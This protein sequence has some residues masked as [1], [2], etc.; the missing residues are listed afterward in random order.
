MHWGAYDIQA[1]LK[2]VL[3]G[4][5]TGNEPISIVCK[6]SGNEQRNISF[7]WRLMIFAM[8]GP[9]EDMLN[10]HETSF[11]QKVAPYLTDTSFRFP[12]IYFAGN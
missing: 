7:V 10:R 6:I 8:Y 12:K 4:N 1:F 11:Y 3:R 2:F 9:W 5:V